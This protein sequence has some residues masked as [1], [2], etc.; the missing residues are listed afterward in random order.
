MALISN[1]HV[2]K[3]TIFSKCN[4]YRCSY[5][6]GTTR[7]LKWIKYV[8][9]TQCCK[10]QNYIVCFFMAVFHWASLITRPKQKKNIFIILGKKSD[11]HHKLQGL[12]WDPPAVYQCIRLNGYNLYFHCSFIHCLTFCGI[13]NYLRPSP[14]HCKIREKTIHQQRNFRK[15]RYTFKYE[16]TLECI[17]GEGHT[18]RE[19]TEKGTLTQK[20]ACTGNA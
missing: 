2:L 10:L 18:C 14:L 9:I 12:N 20:K 17:T 15:Y 5:S 8:R 16:I 6:W 7:G 3:R 19:A 4:D 1:V 11:F 13:Y